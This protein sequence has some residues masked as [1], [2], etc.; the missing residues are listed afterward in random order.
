MLP[1]FVASDLRIGRIKGVWY[2]DQTLQLEHVI[3]MMRFRGLS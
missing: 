2:G 3:I 1:P